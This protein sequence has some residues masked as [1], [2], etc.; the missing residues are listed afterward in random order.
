[1]A[2][3]PVRLTS[4]ALPRARAEELA[5]TLAEIGWPLVAAVS[6]FEEAGGDGWR[7][8]VFCDAA[9][10][11]MGQAAALARVSELAVLAG[12]GSEEVAFVLAPLP[13]VDWVAQV[14]QGLAPVV[15]GRFFVHGSHDRAR[16]RTQGIN[17]EIEARQAFGTGHHGTTRGCLLAL[18][19]LL[20][21]GALRPC[22]RRAPWVLDVGTGSG[23]LGIA[24]AR[25]LKARVA[26]TDIDVVAVQ[27]ARENARFNGVPGMRL[28]VAAG[29][30]HALVRCM[31]GR[32]RPAWT[33]AARRAGLALVRQA[34]AASRVPQPA[35]ARW[36]VLKPRRMAAFR[37]QRR[38]YD[39]VFA[40]ILAR[41]LMRMAGDL[42]GQVKPG[43]WLVLSGLMV[44]QE[45]MVLAVFEQHGL[46][47]ARRWRLEGWSTLLL[48]R[49]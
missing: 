29:M 40:N 6:A 43:G 49:H 39:L 23:V 45:R 34:L 20:R 2:D 15:A 13:D 47:L 18:E 14:Q 21:R 28:A 10:Q 30:R 26:A 33:M 46:R 41:P 37:F 3:T 25:A 35:Y 1:M 31:G 9:G 4:A 12:A 17:I 24:A 27:T 48:H 5:A 44:E 8:E 36:R 22:G 7:V 16:R 32:E 42:A 11:G 38:G 19:W